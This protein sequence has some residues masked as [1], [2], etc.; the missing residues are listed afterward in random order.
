[1]THRCQ[2]ILVVNRGAASQIGFADALRWEGIAVQS[3]NGSGLALE[4]IEG[5]ATPD[6]ILI[7]LAGKD[8]CVAEF[9]RR[10]KATY[11]VP[12]IAISS[13]SSQ[14]RIGPTADR[15]LHEPFDV[16]E[17]LAVLDELCTSPRSPAGRGR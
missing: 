15:E 8:T 1:M 14:C 5:G 9:L 3:V 7:D 2:R 12:V 16:R 17:L 11:A 10:V 4:A 13:G 6:A